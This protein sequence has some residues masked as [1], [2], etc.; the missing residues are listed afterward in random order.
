[1]TSNAT[2]TTT[3]NATSMSN[4]NNNNDDDDDLPPVAANSWE[5][6]QVC[7][8]FRGDDQQQRQQQQQQQ[9]HQQQQ[10]QPVMWIL[11]DFGSFPPVML[12]L[13]NVLPHLCSFPH[14]CPQTFHKT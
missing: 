10:Q 6:L 7:S 12:G 14:T 3:S 1:M 4:N 2:T 8:P 9:Q 5:P 11:L 13:L